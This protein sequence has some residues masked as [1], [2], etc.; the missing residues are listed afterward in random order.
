MNRK[1]LLQGRKYAGWFVISLLFFLHTG[2]TS[3]ND[4][5]FGN[6]FCSNKQSILFGRGCKKISTGSF[7]ILSGI[8]STFVALWSFRIK[9]GFLNFLYHNCLNKSF[10][11]YL[12]PLTWYYWCLV[13]V[14]V[15]KICKTTFYR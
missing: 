14:N 1:N 12:Q 6:S 2:P 11:Y 13:T 7:K 4:R 10:C 9:I 3:S 15:W 8:S 5:L